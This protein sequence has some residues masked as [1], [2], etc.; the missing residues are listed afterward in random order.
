MF[1]FMLRRFAPITVRFFST[2]DLIHTMTLLDRCYSGYLD[3]TEP[4]RTQFL[5]AKEL[6]RR[7]VRFWESF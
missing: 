1:A 6:I 5:I 4:G 7:K 3:N 2:D